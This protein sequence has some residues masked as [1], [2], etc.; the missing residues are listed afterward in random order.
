[1]GGESG[2]KLPTDAWQEPTCGRGPGQERGGLLGKSGVDSVVVRG[3]N[4]QGTGSMN[5]PRTRDNMV[6]RASDTSGNQGRMRSSI[7]T[8]A[9]E[10][11]ADDMV[12][13]KEGA[14]GGSEWGLQSQGE[15]TG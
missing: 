1:M 5:P 11:N 15:V 4:R 10:L 13:K 8:V 12:L 9:R 6:A 7:V 2:T 3:G 14:R